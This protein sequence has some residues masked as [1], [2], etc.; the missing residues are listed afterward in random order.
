LVEIDI[1]NAVNTVWSILTLHSY[2]LVQLSID[3]FIAIDQI[4]AIDQFL[5]IGR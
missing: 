4:I 1:D 2:E 5:A 3:Q